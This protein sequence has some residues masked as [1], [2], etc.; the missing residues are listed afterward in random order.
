[1]V[2]KCRGHT[3]IPPPHSEDFMT[4]GLYISAT[5]P[6]AAKTIIAVGVTEL[7]HRR[8]TRVGFFRPITEADTPENDTSLQYFRANYSLTNENSGVGLTRSEAH[9]LIASG[10]TEE[11][12]T[13]TLETYSTLAANT[14]V[15][16]IEGTD[17]TGHDY[18]SEFELNARLANHLSLIH[19]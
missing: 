18:G 17:L 2:G 10:R 7:L 13:R 1:M 14:D 11:I 16:V 4:R 5:A 3:Y 19:I 9:E 8:A 6:G 12:Y 15:I